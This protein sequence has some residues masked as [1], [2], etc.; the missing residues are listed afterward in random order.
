MDIKKIYKIRKKDTQEFVSLGYNNKSKWNVYP[1]AAIK[2]SL[3][4]E[5][6]VNYEV[7]VFE[8]S[9]KEVNVIDLK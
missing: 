2:T 1:S 6:K 4:N 9:L 8:Y 7:V 3:R 5:N